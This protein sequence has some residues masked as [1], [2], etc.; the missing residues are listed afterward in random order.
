MWSK[1]TQKCLEIHEL[2]TLTSS[3][4]QSEKS[5]QVVVSFTVFLSYLTLVLTAIECKGLSSPY[6][7][8]GGGGMLLGVLGGVKVSQTPF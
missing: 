2:A 3:K 1:N 8:R 4:K 5:Y 6:E 7:G